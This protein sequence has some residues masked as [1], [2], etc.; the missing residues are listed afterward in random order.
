MPIC[1]RTGSAAEA[2]DWVE[3]RGLRPGT[4]LPHHR[5]CG[6]PHPA[7]ERR[8]HFTGKQGLMVSRTRGVA[9]PRCLT[10]SASSSWP[11]FATF[12][13]NC[14]PPSTGVRSVPVAA[15]FAVVRASSSTAARSSSECGAV[16]NLPVDG[17]CG[18]PRPA[19]SSPTSRERRRSRFSLSSALSFFGPSHRSAFSFVRT[20]SATT[21][22]AD[23]PA[24][25]N[26]G[27]SPGQGRFFPLAP[28]GS[29]ACRW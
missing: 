16:S 28:L 1:I 25:L 10:H 18:D 3:C 11:Q 15:A 2:A 26:A 12:L 24:S 22:S 23:F 6:F 5:T 4:T 17:G 21:A 27:I 14:A 8:F 9:T 19:G 13:W 20:S 29:T 7:V